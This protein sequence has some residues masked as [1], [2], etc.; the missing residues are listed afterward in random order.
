MGRY[1]PAMR[2]DSP[3]SHVVQG[4]GLRI[5]TLVWEAEAAP[6]DG[7]PT[8]LLLLHGYLDCG[9]TFSPLVSQLPPWLRVLAPDLRGHGESGRVP[10][11]CWYH[12]VDYVRDVRA[13]VDAL[14][15]SGRLVLLGHSMGGGV[16]ALFAG[17]W[18]EEV[19]RL[20]LVEGLGPPRED[21]SGA[22][23]RLARWVRELDAGPK[24]AR[25]FATAEEA[26][27]R[28]VRQNPVMPPSRALAAVRW[29]A[30]EVDGSWQWRHDPWH[31]ARTPQLY[32]PERY[33]PF[34][35]AITVPVL[36]VTGGRSWYR[37]D[38]L[39]ERRAHL[40]DRRRLHLDE[41]GHMVHYEVPGVLGAAVVEFLE[42]REPRGSVRP[43][44]DGAGADPI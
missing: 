24:P 4:S 21:A 14:H 1:P 44:A 15:G 38:D 29:L 35:H 30:E 43:A 33:R 37:W 32:Q 31:R 8:T 11:G 2:T 36:L 28:L 13:V 7:P 18:P 6:P 39:E 5:R 27:A 3:T 9:G 23:S 41:V 22:P 10:H 25:G 16:G 34:M 12:Y 17:A 20:I 40:V 19:E 26:A 42:G